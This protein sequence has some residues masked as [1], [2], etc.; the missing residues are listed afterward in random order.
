M[1]EFIKKKIRDF[2]N[3]NKFIKDC[4]DIKKLFGFDATISHW[5]STY[6]NNYKFVMFNN[7]PHFYVKIDNED[8]CFPISDFKKGGWFIVED[9]FDNKLVLAVLEKARKN[10]AITK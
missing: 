7:R 8:V 2:K 10:N 3:H 4:K 9:R 1:F 6:K 5:S